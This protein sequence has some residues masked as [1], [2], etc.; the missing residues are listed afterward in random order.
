[1][2]LVAPTL[3]RQILATPSETFILAK[4]LIDHRKAPTAGRS[5]MENAWGNSPALRNYFFGEPGAKRA[6]PRERRPLMMRRPELV[7]M[8]LRKPCLR[9]RRLLCG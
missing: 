4:P 3:Y 5:F 6:R 1:M 2:E 9:R 7:F 8:R